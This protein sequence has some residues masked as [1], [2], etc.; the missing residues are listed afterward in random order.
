MMNVNNQTRLNSEESPELHRKQSRTL[1]DL[2]ETANLGED[3]RDSSMQQRA[4]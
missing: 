1:E 4:K 2:R 3:R